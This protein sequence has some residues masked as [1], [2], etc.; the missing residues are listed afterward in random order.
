M[1]Q[2]RAPDTGVSVLTRVFHKH[3]DHVPDQSNYFSSNPAHSSPPHQLP[4]CLPSWRTDD[5]LLN[6]TCQNPGRLH[7]L[8]SISSTTFILFI[9]KPS[10]PLPQSL[11]LCLFLVSPLNCCKVSCMAFSLISIQFKAINAVGMILIQ[12]KSDRVLSL[13]QTFRWFP[14]LWLCFSEYGIHSWVCVDDFKDTERNILY[15][16]LDIR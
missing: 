7:V 12:G 4:L 13:L 14:C 9:S 6:C 16:H 5:Y 2:S 8:L 3:F 10:A 1:P 11:S 15:T